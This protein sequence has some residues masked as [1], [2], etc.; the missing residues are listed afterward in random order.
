MDGFTNDTITTHSLPDL[1]G[2]PT[3]PISLTYRTYH[4]AATLLCVVLPVLGLLSAIRFNPVFPLP[5]F[6]QSAY[7][8]ILAVV[9]AL[10]VCYLVYAYLACG[11]IR[12]SLREHDLTLKKGVICKQ[13]ICQPMLRIQHVE[14]KQGPI[15]R[16]A[17]LAKLHVYSAGGAAHTFLIPGLEQAT[18]EKLRAYILEHK[19]LNAG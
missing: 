14:L 3:E 11:R 13:V 1:K 19:D 15:D 9:V 2:L 18:A 10:S 8:Y 12:Y 6:L 5:V 16:F 17:G 4:I 7:P